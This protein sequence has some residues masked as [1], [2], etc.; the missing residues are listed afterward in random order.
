M[1]GAAGAGVRLVLLGAPGVGKGTQA[2]AIAARLGVPHISTGDLLRAA[3][4]EGSPLGRMVASIVERGELVPDALIGEVVE[5]RLSRKDAERGFILDGFPR[6]LTQA[7]LLDR[8]LAGR[9]EVLDRVILIEVPEPV[10][11]ERLAGRRF[12]DRCGATYHV[13]FSPP[14]VDEICDR[15]GAALRQRPDDAEAVI[16]E[17]FRAYRDQTAPLVARYR[18]AGRLVPIDG[19]GR[20][21]EVLGRIAVAVPGLR[22]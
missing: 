9:G 16:A 18:N 7:D 17:R 8:F 1:N 5:E 4:R 13:R 11:V 22:A 12:C 3:I 20:P 19:Q 14:K 6:T 15:C 21:E 2:D 10:I